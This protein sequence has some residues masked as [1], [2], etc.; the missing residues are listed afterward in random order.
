MDLN[1]RAFRVVQAATGEPAINHSKIDASRRG[2][3]KGGKVR[4]ALLSADRR[5]EI[6]R[7]ASVARW[8]REE[9]K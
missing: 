1:V 7:K 2:G 5:T 6:A 8:N 3:Q 4:A 9:I